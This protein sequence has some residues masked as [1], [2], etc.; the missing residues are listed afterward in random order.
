MELKL[1][2]GTVRYFGKLQNNAK[3]GDDL[4]LGIEWDEEGTGKNNG[5]VDGYTY[6]VP[7]VNSAAE[8]PSCSFLRYGKIKIGGIE[9][10]DAIIQKY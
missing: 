7:F 9:M 3:A 10:K 4:W 5:T 1:K 6:F 2:Y 8:R